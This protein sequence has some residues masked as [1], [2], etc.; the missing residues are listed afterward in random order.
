M[1]YFLVDHFGLH[2][3]LLFEEQTIKTTNV[4]F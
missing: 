4:N 3:P 2:L 1:K